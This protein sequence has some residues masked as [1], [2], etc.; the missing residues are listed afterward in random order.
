MDS[1]R[2]LHATATGTLMWAPAAAISRTSGKTLFPASSPGTGTQQPCTGPRSPAQAA[3]S[4]SSP[5]AT[6]HDQPRSDQD[7]DRPRCRPS[8][9]SSSTSLRRCRSPSRPVTAVRGPCGPRPRRHRGTLWDRALP[10]AHPSSK[11][12]SSQVRCQPNSGQSHPPGVRRGSRICLEGMR[13]GTAATWPV[14]GRA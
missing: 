12:R 8:A 11:D 4:A 5:H 10:R 9:S 2:T 7:G 1:L 3:G 6:R 13:C 14:L